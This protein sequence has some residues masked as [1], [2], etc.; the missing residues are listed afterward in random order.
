[1]DIAHNESDKILESLEK[2]LKKLYATCYKKNKSEFG[3]VAS[4]LFKNKRLTL[5]QQS[6]LFE[7]IK[8]YET[9]INQLADEIKNTNITASNMINSEMINIY[10]ANYNYGA[11]MVENAS[12]YECGY[13]IYNKSAIKNLLADN[14]NPFTMISLDSAKDKDIIYRLLKR[15][16]VAAII[17]GETIEE[18]AKRVKATTEKSM[19]DSIRIAR[20]ETTRIESLGRQNSFKYGE[21][22]GLKLSKKW[23]STAD[24]RTR[25]SHLKMM[26]ETVGLDEKFSNG[27]DFPGG[28]GGRA[29]EVCNCRCTHVVEFD[30]IKKGANEIK[31][32]NDLKDMAYSEWL[33]RQSKGD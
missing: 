27:L 24:S 28:I 3:K 19:S 7:E 17:N 5:E 4:K 21:K 30:G 11:Y 22:M 14:I 32:N 9:I 16:F 33:R 15:Q 6:E 8:R 13:N 25:E 18:I 12:G 10:S 1:M 23:V 31:L 26:N 29:S 2:E 20:T